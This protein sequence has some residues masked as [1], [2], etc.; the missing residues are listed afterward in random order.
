M[1][2][3]FGFSTRGLA[4]HRASEQA[5]LILVTSDGWLIALD[6]TSG[7]TIESFGDEC[8]VD[9]RTGLRRPLDPIDT[10]WSSVPTVC[11]D[12]IVVGSQNN[13]NSHQNRAGDDPSQWNLPLGDI[14]GFDVKTG[15]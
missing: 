14:R 3:M 4:Y 5:R 10:F 15:E 13:D 11:G 2:P 6:P 12:V 7:K 8:R 9:L 1:P